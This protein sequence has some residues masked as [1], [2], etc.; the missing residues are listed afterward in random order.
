[1]FP[2]TDTRLTIILFLDNSNSDSVRSDIE[3]IEITVNLLFD[4]SKISFN[5]ALVLILWKHR[6][7]GIDIPK[8]NDTTISHKHQISLGAFKHVS[9]ESKNTKEMINFLNDS[10]LQQ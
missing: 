2:I 3:K 10:I 5:Y 1:M 9:Y 6:F 7:V 4:K 8:S